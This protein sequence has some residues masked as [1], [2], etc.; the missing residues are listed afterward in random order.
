[1][2]APTAEVPLDQMLADDPKL[3]ARAG[4]KAVFAIFDKWGLSIDQGR[5][6]LDMPRSTYMTVKKDPES[7][8]RQLTNDRLSRMSYVLGI[9]KALRIFFSGSP[10]AD[11]WVKRPNEGRG[12][13]GKP[14]IDKMTSGRMDDLRYVREYL[15]GMLGW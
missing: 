2:L 13:D 1:M 15:E 3:V 12:F 8:E 6:I 4:F 11:G 10:Q 14:A 5:A 9:Y 7:G